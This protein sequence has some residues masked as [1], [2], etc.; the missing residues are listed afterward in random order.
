MFNLTKKSQLLSVAE[1][2]KISGQPYW[3]GYPPP[4]NREHRSCLE[5][6][7]LYNANRDNQYG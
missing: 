6:T 2:N 5:K 3:D 7:H 1:P 4:K